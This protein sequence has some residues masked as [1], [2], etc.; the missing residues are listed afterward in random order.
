MKL[1]TSAKAFLDLSFDM[2]N[3]LIE[4]YMSAYYS[5]NQNGLSLQVHFLR[6]TKHFHSFLPG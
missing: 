3:I 1:N 4:L 5:H 6:V 2:T